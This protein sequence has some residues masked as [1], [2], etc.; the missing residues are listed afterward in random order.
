[1][2]ELSKLYV[3]N[4]SRYCV[5]NQSVDKVPF[6]PWP[7]DP[8]KYR[9]LPP[10]ILH[11]CIKYQSCMLKTS[12]YE[13][14]KLYHKNC[15]SYRVRTK[16]VIKFTCDL[17]LWPFGLKMYICLPLTIL[18][19]CMK[20]QS[21]ML[22][23]THV[24]VSEPKCWQTTVMTL[25]FDLW[26][27]DLQMYRYLSHIILRWCLKN[28]SVCWNPL[29]LSCQNQSVVKFQWWPWPFTFSSPKCIG[30]FLSPSC[31]YMYNIW[32]LY[33]EKCNWR[34]YLLTIHSQY[35]SELNVLK[36]RYAVK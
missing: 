23:T 34:P 36:S 17:D 31:I 8:K 4:Y 9:Y 30:I 5:K 32:K 21:C 27:F 6:W 1:M 28:K 22:K 26:P 3:E 20:Y 24:I 13:I 33:I 11:L 35:L 2:Y 14:L 7:L 19:L 29:K 16:V 10:T 18:H 25:T 15:T 12:M